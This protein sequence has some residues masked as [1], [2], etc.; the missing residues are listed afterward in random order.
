MVDTERIQNMQY[1]Y[2]TQSYHTHVQ[3]VQKN[4]N[5]DMDGCA[6]P[7]VLG[8]NSNYRRVYIHHMIFDSSLE[9]VNVQPI[10]IYVSLG[11][12]TRFGLEQ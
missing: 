6:L 5:T 3:H 4:N 9:Q 8:L 11:T 12:T 10:Q 7:P 2:I 1:T